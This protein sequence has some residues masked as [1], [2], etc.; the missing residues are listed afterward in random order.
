MAE[1]IIYLSDVLKTMSTLDAQGL[2]VPFSISFRTF[3]RYSKTGGRLI[4]YPKAKLVI[5]ENFSNHNSIDSLRRVP[6]KKTNIRRNPNHWENKTRNIKILPKGDIKKIHI[7][8]IT[9][10]NGKK[11]V[12]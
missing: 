1:E 3:Q 2:A 11:V 6:T 10:F 5:K 8:F 7:N 12:L 9:E 4:S